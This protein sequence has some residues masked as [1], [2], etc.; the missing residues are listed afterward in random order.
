MMTGSKPDASSRIQR[1][2][3][4]RTIPK[5][6]T[7]DYLFVFMRYLNA[8]C[9]NSAPAGR[10][11]NGFAKKPV[12]LNILISHIFFI[13]PDLFGSGTVVALIDW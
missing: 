7:N 6:R 8:P 10:F 12:N 2:G 11:F 5:W 9:A 13:E 3:P 1:G 4:N